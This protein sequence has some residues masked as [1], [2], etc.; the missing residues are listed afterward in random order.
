MNAKNCYYREQK[1]QKGQKGQEG[2]KNSQHTSTPQETDSALHGDDLSGRCASSLR[3]P[4][5]GQGAFVICWRFL[6]V[7]VTFYVIVIVIVVIVII[8]VIIIIVIIIIIII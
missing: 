4:V 6:S 7:F 2:D 8:I 1:E 3:L 5:L